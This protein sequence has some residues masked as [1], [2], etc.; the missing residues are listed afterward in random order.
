MVNKSNLIIN[1]IEEGA[2]SIE[3]L[4]NEIIAEKFPNLW[5]DKKYLKWQ[6]DLDKKRLFVSR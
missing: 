1:G 6:I 2:K 5:K 4:F 3:K